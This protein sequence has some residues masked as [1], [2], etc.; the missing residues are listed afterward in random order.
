MINIKDV[1]NFIDNL[2]YKRID[3]NTCCYPTIYKIR[4]YDKDGYCITIIL[5]TKENYIDINFPKTNQIRITNISK[6][7]ILDLQR[8][9]IAAEECSK[10]AAEYKFRHYFDKMNEIDKTIDNLDDDED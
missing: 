5:N 4:F 6:I 3:F 8:T 7:D 2:I 1:I 9:F 10:A